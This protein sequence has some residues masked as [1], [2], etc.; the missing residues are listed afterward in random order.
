[1]HRFDTKLSDLFLLAEREKSP[2]RHQHLNQ[3]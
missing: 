3:Q 1:M 2:I